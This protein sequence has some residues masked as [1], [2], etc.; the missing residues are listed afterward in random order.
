MAWIVESCS[1]MVMGSSGLVAL[2]TP[3]GDDYGMLY[4]P[5]SKRC[6]ASFWRRFSRHHKSRWG[7][8]V[9]DNV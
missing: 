5:Y 9:L 3:Q 6:L 4:A 1:E 7:S 8:I 2:H